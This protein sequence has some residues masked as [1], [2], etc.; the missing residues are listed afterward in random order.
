MLVYFL[1]KNRVH[2]GKINTMTKKDFFRIIMKCLGL[3]FIVYILFSILPSNITFVLMAPDIS[4]IIWI[5]LVIIVIL[6]IA[7]ILFKPDIIIKLLKLDQGFDEDRIDLPNFNSEKIL[8]LAIMII[9]G[10]IIIRYLPEF[11]TRSLVATKVLIGGENPDY[12]LLKYN[13]QKDTIYWITSIVNLIIGFIMLTKY[14]LISRLI[15]YKTNKDKLDE[16]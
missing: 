2:R 5:I 8:K 3:Y 1:E 16:F 13:S 7:F 12:I 10:I 9:G 4:G 15:N 11:M 6:I 14:N